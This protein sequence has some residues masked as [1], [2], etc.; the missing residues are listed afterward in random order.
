MLPS[1]WKN[2]NRCSTKLIHVCQKLQLP[3]DCRQRIYPLLIFNVYIFS[4]LG[5]AFAVSFLRYF[6]KLQL[7]VIKI[8]FNNFCCI[9][10][11]FVWAQK[12]CLRFLKSYFKLEILIFFVLRGVFFSRYIQLE[13]S[14]FWRKKH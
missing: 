1:K 7:L 14:F 8:F 6:Q 5:V 12:A 10:I 13:S 2:L 4:I 11:L 3:L 9:V